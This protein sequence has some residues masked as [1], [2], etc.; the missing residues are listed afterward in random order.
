MFM[1][2]WSSTNACTLNENSLCKDVMSARPVT[3]CTD[4]P[5][6][7]SAITMPW[8]MH[9]FLYIG[10]TLMPLTMDLWALCVCRCVVPCPH[11]LSKE[12][13]ELQK[14]LNVA[15]ARERQRT[16]DESNA[17][18]ERYEARLRTQEAT[19]Q[20]QITSLR[21]AHTEELQSAVQ[22]AQQK[23][24]ADVAALESQL[25]HSK[26]TVSRSDDQIIELKVCLGAAARD[27]GG[28]LR[29]QSN[30]VCLACPGIDELS[31][32]MR[33]V[34]VAHAQSTLADTQLQLKSAK[35]ELAHRV[36]VLETAVADTEAKLH[37]ERSRLTDELDATKRSLSDA[38]AVVASQEELL[39]RLRN[40]AQ[41]RQ[42]ALEEAKTAKADAKDAADAAERERA[43]V[44]ADVECYRGRAEDLQQR[45]DQVEDNL[46]EKDAA[47]AQV[48]V[49]GCVL[50]W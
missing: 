17:L 8:V 50:R 14:E 39:E 31:P 27:G 48:R 5:T 22:A 40:E 38:K 16:A 43:R 20:E 4:V 18:Q 33:S 46:M 45:L 21:R 32:M 26:E 24:E 41:A 15:V 35:A 49:G 47:L 42:S 23:L 9:H 3:A 29:Q 36:E 10:Y 12:V 13:E 30:L 11:R 25:K 44:V 19:Y 7:L 2:C 37:S 1:M 34:V 6:R 28:G